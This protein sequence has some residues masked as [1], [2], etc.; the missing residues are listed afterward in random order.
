LAL[1]ALAGTMIAA[2]GCATGPKVR[3]NYDK[4]VDFSQY[5]T[6]GF[7]SPLGTDTARYQ[8]IVSQD[9]KEATQRGLEA[10]GLRYTETAP[11]LLVNFNAKLSNQL[12]A[13]TMPATAGYGYY[14]YR[15]GAYA[16]W[17]M[18]SPETV[19]STYT[20]GTLNIDIVDA[21]RKQL[22]WEGVAVG[23]VTEKT[24]QNLQSVID[25]TVAKVLEQYP[26][27]APAAAH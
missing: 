16:A 25:M 12:R 17:P 21:A 14:G 19:V 9:L 26:V 20:E 23:S 1:I 11:Q 8:S 18:Y 6:F 24:S 5:K 10:R 4:S 3:A 13:D 7:F 27:S 22:V 2:A 15:R